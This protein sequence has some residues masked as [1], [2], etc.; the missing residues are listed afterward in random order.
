MAQTTTER[1]YRDSG[2]HEKPAHL[3]TSYPRL[4]CTGDV[5]VPRANITADSTR[6]NMPSM[7]C[8]RGHAA[9]VAVL[10]AALAIPATSAAYSRIDALAH[11]K[12]SFKGAQLTYAL[13][14]FTNGPFGDAGMNMEFAE[15]AANVHFLVT[16]ERGQARGALLALGK[17]SAVD[18]CVSD[19]SAENA[20]R[21]RNAGLSV[22]S[23]C[24]AVISG[25]L[26]G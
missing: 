26:A 22:R 20:A 4:A 9:A 6:A 19:S 25:V 21:A 5:S 18:T 11:L 2:E 7:E 1:E 8:V 12:A 24:E 17:A 16:A 14:M 23:A 10:A 15:S 13:R 3:L